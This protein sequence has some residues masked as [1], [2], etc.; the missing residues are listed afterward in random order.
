MHLVIALQVGE[1]LQRY[2]VV[3]GSDIADFHVIFLAAKAFQHRKDTRRYL[4]VPLFGILSVCC[5]DCLTVPR[6]GHGVIHLAGN[7][8]ADSPL[9]VE[10]DFTLLGDVHAKELTPGNKFQLLD[11]LFQVLLVQLDGGQEAH[12]VGFTGS[13]HLGVIL[14]KEGGL[15]GGAKG[16]FG[17]VSEPD[18]FVHM[19]GDGFFVID[20]DRTGFRISDEFSKSDKF[21]KGRCVDFQSVERKVGRTRTDMDEAV[22]VMDVQA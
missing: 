11:I 16:R 8:L 6:E 1:R 15:G 18:E 5:G 14:V 3:V 19:A 4:A 17:T 9:E 20:N 2:G 22:L 21:D 7:L 10:L 12:R 13:R